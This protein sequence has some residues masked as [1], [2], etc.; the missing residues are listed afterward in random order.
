MGLIPS[1]GP[2]VVA[3]SVFWVSVG[4]GQLWVNAVYLKGP[5]RVPTSLIRGVMELLDTHP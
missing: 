1:S 5:M 3:Q 2:T 4:R